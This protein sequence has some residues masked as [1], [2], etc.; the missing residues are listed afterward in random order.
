MMRVSTWR[1]RSRTFTNF[2]WPRNLPA[3]LLADSWPKPIPAQECSVVPPMLTEAIPVEAVMPSV[4]DEEPPDMRIISRK[5]TDLPVPTFQV[6]ICYPFWRRNWQ[7]IRLTSWTSEE[8]I[9]PFF[10]PFKNNILFRRE[11]YVRCAGV[12]IFIIITRFRRWF[13]A[14]QAGRWMWRF[15]GEALTFHQIVWNTRCVGCGYK[16]PRI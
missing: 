2:G 13:Q 16:R 5:R 8:D 3:R 12:F 10:Y 11:H 9:A 4:A 1:Q 6:R 14:F 7:K 15:R